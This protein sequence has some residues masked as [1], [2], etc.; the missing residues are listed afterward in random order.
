MPTVDQYARIIL[1]QHTQKP[2]CSLLDHLL[3]FDEFQKQ[4]R[5]LPCF[6]E[7][8]VQLSDLDLWLILRYLVHHYGV[9]VRD[10]Y[11]TFGHQ[12]VAI[13]M[14][15]R[16][17]QQT[18]AEITEE[19]RA[20]VSLKTACATL[21]HQVDKLQAKSQELLLSAKENYKFNRKPQAIY[22]LKKKKQIEEV[23][24]QR[25]RT[26]DTMETVLLKIEAAQN[27]LQVIQAFNLGTETLRSILAS[28][29]IDQVEET[30]DQLK[31][32]LEEHEQT[33]AAWQSFLPGEDDELEQQLLALQLE[34]K[35]TLTKPIDTQSELMRLQHVL[36]T[37]NHPPVSQK[38][39]PEFA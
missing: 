19:D 14:P 34:D 3:S 4:Y 7:T 25:Y 38:K 36:S 39:Q 11:K 6:Q 26:L 22:R 35:P 33:E 15:S 27:D 37:L 21:H 9:C 32:T 2:L 13:K 31:T 29:S 17:E 24:E 28:H 23:L 12:T 20:I 5:S 10:T 8:C 1:Q 30:M 18:A 16:T